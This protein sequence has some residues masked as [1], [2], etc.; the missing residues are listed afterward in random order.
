MNTYFLILLAALAGSGGYYLNTSADPNKWLNTALAVSC[1]VIVYLVCNM[2]SVKVYRFCRS[3]ANGCTQLNSE[4]DDFTN[5]VYLNRLIKPRM[6]DLDNAS[7]REKEVYRNFGSPALPAVM[8]VY[9]DGRNYKYSGPMTSSDIKD[10]V[11]N[12]RYKLPGL[13]NPPGV[14][15]ILGK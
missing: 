5:G 10:F 3:S 15:A 6:I 14:V 11:S 1:L 2:F 8:C 9:P 12:F 4:W 13:S 7:D